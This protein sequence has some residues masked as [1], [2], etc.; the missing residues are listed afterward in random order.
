MKFSFEE[1][2]L[3][4]I[5]ICT[6][7]LKNC[8]DSIKKESILQY[9]ASI[10]ENTEDKELNSI[11]ESTVEKLNLMNDIEVEKTLKKLFSDEFIIPFL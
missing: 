10:K 3:I 6:N 2:E 5:A 8:S 1:A 9:L 7:V 11:L 4:K